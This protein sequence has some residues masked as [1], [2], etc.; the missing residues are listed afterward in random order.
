MADKN[1]PSAIGAM[2]IPD[3]SAL[4]EFPSCMAS[5]KANK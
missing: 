5:A 3:S 1:C 2:D 4:M